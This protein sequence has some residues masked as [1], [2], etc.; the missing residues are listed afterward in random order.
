MSLVLEYAGYRILKLGFTRLF[1][2]SD[3]CEMISMPYW[4]APP[5]AGGTMFTLLSGQCGALTPWCNSPAPP[6]D[7]LSPPEVAMF[8]PDRSTAVGRQHVIDAGPVSE[9]CS[10]QVS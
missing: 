8:S 2:R 10:L 9:D 1:I 4:F 7:E 5:L 3:K 6:P